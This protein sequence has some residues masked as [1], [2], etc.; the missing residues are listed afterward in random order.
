MQTL[1]YAEHPADVLARAAGL[2][3]QN[4]RFALITSLSIQGGAAR[5]V[6]SLAL[7]T[8]AGDMIGYLS[9][10]CIDR[11]IQLQAQNALELGERAVILYGDGSR[12]ADLKLPCG[13]SLEVLIDPS[14]DLAAISS[15]HAALQDRRAA[16]LQ[17]ATANGEMVAFSY[18]PVFRLV[19]AGR[20]AIFRSTAIAGQAAGFDMRCMS[21]DGDD[22]AAVQPLCS[23][24][25]MHL[26]TPDATQDLPDL[27]KHS[28]FLTL[29][30]DH[31]WEPALL[32]AA[33]QT[34][35][36]FIGSLGSLKTH[37][38]R[39]NRLRDM[40]ASDT[41]LARLHGPIGLVPSLRNA[42]AIAISTLAEVIAT[43]PPMITPEYVT[44]AV[45]PE[46][47]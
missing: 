29:F 4:R 5:D 16:R 37:A 21:P 6:G 46:T 24:K 13:G 2:I 23:A 35:A 20:G 11:D 34:Q 3:T 19:L 1:D 36:D 27:D 32:Q 33:L 12:Y 14:P 9:N 42:H 7:V 31:D 8:D 40:G 44:Q 43:M 39:L 26:T 25:P 10:G 30:H 17:F 45:L 47:A 38:A 41:D 18:A 28:A 22:L 15:A